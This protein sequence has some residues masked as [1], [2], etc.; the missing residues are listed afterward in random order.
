MTNVLVFLMKPR[1][2][3]FCWVQSAHSFDI[4]SFST[5][6]MVGFPLCTHNTHIIC[7]IVYHLL[8]NSCCMLG[9]KFTQH[10]SKAEAKSSNFWNLSHKVPKVGSFFLPK[11][12]SFLQ[13]TNRWT[14]MQNLVFIK[15]VGWGR[16]QMQM[17]DGSKAREQN[18]PPTTT[19]L[20]GA[21]HFGPIRP[22]HLFNNFW[23]S[24]WC[25]WWWWTIVKKP[26][27]S[28]WSQGDQSKHS[29]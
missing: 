7:Q 9:N 23:A 21:C 28:F 19:K 29:R 24:W 16:L 13:A 2:C 17:R 12:K 4:A 1:L 5:L 20:E 27:D 25:W 10:V 6:Y 11:T 26:R 8:L 15:I 18:T 14:N 3:N 22:P